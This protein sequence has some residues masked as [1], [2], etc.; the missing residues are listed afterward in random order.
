[1]TVGMLLAGARGFARSV[2]MRAFT[3][4]EM[5]GIVSQAKAAEG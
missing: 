1:M 4:D 5:E 2:T 3:M